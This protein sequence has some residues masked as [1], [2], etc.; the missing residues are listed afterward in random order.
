M[1]TT[2]VLLSLSAFFA[3]LVDAI[4]GGGGLITVPALLMAGL[5][6]ALALGTNKLQASFGSFSA[7]FH[8]LRSG[9]VKLKSLRL[10]ILCSAIGASIGTLTIL[11]LD[12]SDLGKVIP[13]LLLVVF[14]YVLFSPKVGMK[15]SRQRLNPMLAIILLGLLIGFYDGFL[16]AGT[17]SFWAI[18]LIFFLG[19]N[20]KQATMQ[21]KVY[22]FTSNIV[23]LIWFIAA[24]HV[25]WLL[26][27]CMGVGQLVG[28]RV[29]AQLVLT[30][31]SGF[32]RPLFLLV[33][34]VLLIVQIIKVY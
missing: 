1:I 18:S 5:P 12:P 30:K 14:V 26:G 15:Q 20:F 23:S 27:L 31:G 7:S 3:G 28:A 24:G 9:E 6:P 22:N 2:F 32:I 34:L 19:L 25:L 11:F 17:G 33:V 16:G 4:A 8:F 10:G 21:T 13:V 29:G